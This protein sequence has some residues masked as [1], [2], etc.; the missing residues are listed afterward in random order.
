[1]SKKLYFISLLVASL[2]GGLMALGFS[3]LFSK[4]GYATITGQ[5]EQ[6]NNLQ[7]ILKNPQFKVP[8][9]VNF[10]IASDLTKKAVV[11]IRISYKKGKA[12][13][14][15][16]DEEYMEELF[17]QFHGENPKY[18]MPQL[19]S[20]SGVIIS[21]DGYI[22]TNNHVVDNAS[23]IEVVLE[24]KRSFKAQL[25]GKD[26]ST[27]LAL[28]KIEAQELPFIKYAKADEVKVG[29]WV[30]AVGNPFDLTS[31]VT[32]GIVS[33][34]GRNINLLQDNQGDGNYA[35]ESFI[36][37]D[38]AVN[39][40]NSG[41]ALVNLK[42]EL[43][44]INTA[45]ASQTGT[46][47]GYSFAIPVDI[48]KKVTEDLLKYGQVQRGVLGVQIGDIDANIAAQLGLKEVKG[49]YLVGVA[50]NGSAYKAGLREGDIVIKINNRA[51]NTSAELQA[52]IAMYRP[53]DV[54]SIVYIRDKKEATASVTLLS[55]EG[56]TEIVK[57]TNNLKSTTKVLG[58]LLGNVSEEE[59]KKLGIT[60]GVK[61]V[62]ANEGKMREAGIRKGFIITHF[63]EI[64][65][66]DVGDITKIMKN[67]KRI[68]VIEGIY[69]NG[70]KAYYAI[71]Q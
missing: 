5:D 30:L 7:Q 18:K 14:L 26:A 35:I 11:H 53:G 39:P 31:T 25:I 61:V 33:A 34:K 20:G 16:T 56:S 60:H 37:T 2:L 17:R 57:N 4:S 54:L 40:G 9:G 27:D 58:A 32:A 1:M 67:N 41:G 49:V 36:Q 38:A 65:V 22:V 29:E 3:K 21:A 24:D 52:T 23:D 59:L 64:P 43:V 8:D 10:L 51:I 63:G 48:V 12:K 45:I 55:R 42:G 68:I 13:K 19:S 15:N 50:E 71:G 70:D 44:G 28:L 62:E 47:S 46:Y 66:G 6:L 69:P